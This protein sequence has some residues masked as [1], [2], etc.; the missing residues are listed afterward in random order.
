MLMLSNIFCI[1]SIKQVPNKLTVSCDLREENRVLLNLGIAINTIS[2]FLYLS[3]YRYFIRKFSST[4]L[5]Y[6]N[7]PLYPFCINVSGQ[8]INLP[9][10]H[11]AKYVRICFN[12]YNGIRE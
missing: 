3:N 2:D 5:L 10:N 4:F 11:F 12:F 8:E 6:A 1:N 9:A 7:T